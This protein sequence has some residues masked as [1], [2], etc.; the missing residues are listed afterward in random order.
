M[1]RL[2]IKKQFLCLLILLTAV[3]MS[4]CVL[5]PADQ[6][7][8]LPRQSD[9]YYNLQS[10]IEK[11]VTG[12]VSYCAPTEG[13]N[14]QPIQIQDLDGDGINEAIV[15]AKDT[16]ERPLKIFIFSQSGDNYQLV[17]T[18]EGEG[19]SFDSVT[20]AQI[21]GSPGQEIIIGRSVGNQIV[22]SMSIYTFQRS[23][24]VELMSANYSVYTTVDL[25][26][27]GRADLFLIRFDSNTQ[28]GAVE[29]YRFQDGVMVRDPEQALSDGVIDVVRMTTG[30]MDENVPAV[31][32]TGTL[33]S[34]LISTDVFAISN[35]TMQNIAALSDQGEE[36]MVRNYY[37]YSTDIDGD[38]IVELPDVQ[39]LPDLAD[40]DNAT[41]FRLI[42]WYNLHLDGSKEDK[43]LTYHD[44]SYGFYVELSSAWEG[45]IT[46]SLDDSIDEG[47]AYVFNWW[48]GTNLPQ[49]E[50]F[51]LYI[52]S[53]DH[54]DELAQSEGR[55]LLADQNDVTYAASIGNS[56]HA[57]ALTEDSLKASFHFIRMDWKSG[58]M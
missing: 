35:G 10:E 9:A 20:Y 11:L 19:T 29:L 33:E 49:E 43:L 39:T 28:D 38:G 51:T 2:I 56:Q 40:A 41:A 4:G 8:A 21:D 14:R 30:Y 1:N 50:L 52:F 6:L 3:C 25:D 31:F 55:F 18:I 16:G 34:N 7:Y 57:R 44:Y 37:A 27:D 15:F 42:Q 46:V 23:S 45:R 22:N 5:K 48:N 53:G 47:A 32:V 24:T 17:S 54:R 26:E 58:E 36:L 12:T 13:E